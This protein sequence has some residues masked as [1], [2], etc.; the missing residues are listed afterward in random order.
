MSAI[1]LD[2]FSAKF[3]ADE[4]PWGTFTSRD[5]AV[6]RT[7]ILHA[8]GPGPLGRVLE[9]ASGNG[10]NSRAI[11]P[12]ALRLDATEGT[13][14][15]TRLTAE[16]IADWQRSR[17]IELS[18]PARFPRRDY[19]AIVVAEL[20]YYLSHR[21]MGLVAAETGRALRR[22]GRLVLAHHRVDFYDFAQHAAGI[23]TRFL[24]LTGARWQVRRVRQRADWDVLVAC[25]T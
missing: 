7:A 10:S 1:A 6:K 9:L 25:R 23:H 17:A 13:P 19:D 5:E 8:L 12:R 15:G 14:E 20:L 16:A 4:D 3:A 22:G 18:L 2:G 24:R 21:A 11:A